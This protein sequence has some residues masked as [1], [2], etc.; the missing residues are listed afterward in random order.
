MQADPGMHF[1]YKG[2]FLHGD[3]SFLK[4]WAISESFVCVLRFYSSPFNLKGSCPR[5]VG[6]GGG[7]EPATS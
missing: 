4:L 7:V 6:G 1:L 2:S 5:G 3:D